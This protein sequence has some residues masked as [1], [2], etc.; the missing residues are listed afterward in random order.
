MTD[1]YKLCPKCN[2]ALD[3]NV[4]EC[5][6]CWESL[7]VSFWWNHIKKDV[8]KVET[9]WCSW[10]ARI[11]FIVFVVLPLISSVISFIV[12]LISWVFN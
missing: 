7:W 1:S 10:I 3:N 9:K 4:M 5:P 8:K 2:N 11:L 12:W 6:Y